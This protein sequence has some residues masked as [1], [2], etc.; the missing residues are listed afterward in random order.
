[1]EK[2]MLEEYLKETTYNYKIHTSFEN[3]GWPHVVVTENDPG[4][5][6]SNYYILFQGNNQIFN[7]QTGELCANI[8]NNELEI[9]EF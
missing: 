4:G 9:I 1:M 8:V 5:G 2:N 3:N 7:A 6:E